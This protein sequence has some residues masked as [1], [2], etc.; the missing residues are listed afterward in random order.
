MKNDN[1]QQGRRP[2][3]SHHGKRRKRWNFEDATPAP[4]PMLIQGVP[5]SGRQ[6][7]FAFK[8]DDCPQAGADSK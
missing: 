1:H 7:L 8:R 4:P 5:C 3:T 6:V 2:A